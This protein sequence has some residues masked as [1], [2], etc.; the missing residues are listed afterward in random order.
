MNKI[1]RQTITAIFL[2]P[3]AVVLFILMGH[4]SLSGQEKAISPFFKKLEKGD[5]W[6]VKVEQMPVWKRAI[7]SSWV[8]AGE[9]K[10]E[11]SSKE[12]QKLIVNVTN[13]NRPK[14]SQPWELTLVYDG[15][16]EVIDATYTVGDR[17]FSG[18][19]ALNLI[20]LGKEG[21]SIG[22][23]LERLKKAPITAM[24]FDIRTNQQIE[25]ADIAFNDAKA[26][27]LWLPKGDVWWRHF[28]RAK[29]LPVRAELKR[30]SW[31]EKDKKK[32]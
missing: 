6:L 28:N 12:T 13:L 5:W 15:K 10:F 1:E 11:V 8:D 26:H 22:G 19:S 27:Q 20:P 30:T 31:W 7:K 18:D 16:G 23:S 32:Q 17:T 14:D 2:I 29:G 9:W 4:S 25:M 24:G 3:L 21:L